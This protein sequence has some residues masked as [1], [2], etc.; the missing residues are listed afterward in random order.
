MIP[1]GIPPIE[2][3]GE[4][5]RLQYQAWVQ[6]F[7]APQQQPSATLV[8]DRIMRLDDFTAPNTSAARGALALSRQYYSPAMKNHVLRSWYIAEGIAVAHAIEGLDHELLYVS[9]LLHDI[10]ISAEFDNE[11]LSYEHAGGHIGIALT[12]GAGWSSDRRQRVLDVVVRHNWSSVDPDLDPEGYVLEL[13]TGLD[14]T[15]AN[16]DVLPR[17][18]L[19]ELTNTFPRGTFGR[20]FSTAVARQASRKPDTS[21]ARLMANDLPGRM[22][23]HPLEPTP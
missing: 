6:Q 1:G 2:F 9:A 5:P 8:Y 17:S 15:G 11:T 12:A 16:L 14:V 13:A 19:E 20:E 18:F 7:S 22:R 21:A 4:L 3:A 23:R 10:G